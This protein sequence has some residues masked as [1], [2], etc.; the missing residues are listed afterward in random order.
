MRTSRLKIDVKQSQVTNKKN[1]NKTR[2][3]SDSKPLRNNDP[4]ASLAGIIY[5]NVNILLDSKVERKSATVTKRFQTWKIHF[6][7]I[8]QHS[9][10]YFR[11]S[12]TQCIVLN[13]IMKDFQSSGVFNV[14]NFV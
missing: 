4:C 13:V 5:E 8:T 12:S 14:S 11:L 3:I 10:V 2:T 6:N 1:E 7:F 9:T